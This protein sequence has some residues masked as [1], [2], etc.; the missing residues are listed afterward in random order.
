MKKKKK[1]KNEK[2]RKKKKKM[3]KKKKKKKKTMDKKVE[4]RLEKEDEKQHGKVFVCIERWEPKRGIAC[5]IRKYACRRKVCN[6]TRTDN[7][8]YT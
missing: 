1:K 3:D 8:E 2:R 7:G 4:R 6:T 5:T